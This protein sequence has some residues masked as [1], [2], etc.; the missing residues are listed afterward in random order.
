MAISDD[1]TIDYDLK[2]IAHTAGTT[3]YTVLSLYS[4][5]MDDNYK[6]KRVI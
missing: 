1:W 5:L 6:I 2:T 3:V 4:W